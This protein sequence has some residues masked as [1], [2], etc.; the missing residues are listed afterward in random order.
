METVTELMQELQTIVEHEELTNVPSLGLVTLALTPHGTHVFLNRANG[1]ANER[2]A[3]KA[4]IER[5]ESFVD[6]HNALFSSMASAFDPRTK[7]EIAEYDERARAHA[8]QS[9]KE[10]AQSAIQS[11]AAAVAELSE[12]ETEH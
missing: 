1:D 9:K 3:A 6:D 4:I 2:R 8:M 12:S 7:E 10:L 11:I 5:I